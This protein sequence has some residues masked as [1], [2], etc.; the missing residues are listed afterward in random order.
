[1]TRCADVA[2]SETGVNPEMAER[3]LARYKNKSPEDFARIGK[4]LDEAE[5][6]HHEQLE[7]KRLVQ[8]LKER[9]HVNLIKE[10]EDDLTAYDEI[11]RVLQ[12]NSSLKWGS[13]NSVAVEMESQ[14][15]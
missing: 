7:T 1:M 15:A 10:L 8:E 5:L 2:V 14:V 11:K 12:G 13:Q 6:F 9:E 4:D 3:I